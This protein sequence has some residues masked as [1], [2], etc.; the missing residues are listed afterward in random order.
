MVILTSIERETVEVFFFKEK[1]V[2]IVALICR[3]ETVVANMAFS[4]R[5]Q[6]FCVLDYVQDKKMTR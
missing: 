6:S 3:Y 5:E 1:P 4:K 2:H